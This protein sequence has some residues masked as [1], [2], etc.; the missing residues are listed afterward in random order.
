M[1]LLARRIPLFGFS[2]KWNQRMHKNRDP[3]SSQARILHDLLVKALPLWP[4]F[5]I[6]TTQKLKGFS[7]Q[8]LL[9][10]GRIYL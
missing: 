4:F 5:F 1:K 3:N 10:K 2:I 6:K 9:S 8:N 7:S